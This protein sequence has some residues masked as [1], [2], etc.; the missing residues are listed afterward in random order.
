[1]QSLVVNIKLINKITGYACIKMIL[2]PNP[3]DSGVEDLKTVASI[4]S[5][6]LGNLETNP[7]NNF[8]KIGIQNPYSQMWFN[9]QNEFGIKKPTI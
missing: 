3:N 2:I 6:Y 5:K 7:L 1:M 4:L 8:L 9:L